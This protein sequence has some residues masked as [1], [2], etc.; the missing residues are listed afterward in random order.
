MTHSFDIQIGPYDIVLRRTT[1]EGSR[2]R[3]KRVASRGAPKTAERKRMTDCKLFEG[4]EWEPWCSR[5]CILTVRHNRL[6]Y[7]SPCTARNVCQRDVLA[8]DIPTAP[9]HASLLGCLGDGKENLVR[10]TDDIS[11][12]TDRQIVNRPVPKS[13]A[14]R[15]LAFVNR[16]LL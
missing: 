3:G 7:G 5:E 6:R 11:P 14:V 2:L 4:Q 9:H 10:S 16:Y 8:V 12:K 13:K 1:V 15:N